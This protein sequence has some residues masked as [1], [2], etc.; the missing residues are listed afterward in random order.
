MSRIAERKSRYACHTARFCSLC[1]DSSYA[2]FLCNLPLFFL[3]LSTGVFASVCVYVCVNFCLG[4]GC[5]IM[6][7]YVRVR[8]CIDS[9][10]FVETS[11]WN[12][13]SLFQPQAHPAR[14]MQDTFFIKD[15]A[16]TLKI[17]HVSAQRH[18]QHS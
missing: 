3:L 1:A 18:S 4:G 12:F 14:D 6:R 13:D 9:F 7:A 8:V 17:P 5:G 11:F 16:K 10:R 2:S 15:P